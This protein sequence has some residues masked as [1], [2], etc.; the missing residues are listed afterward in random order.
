MT[1]AMMVGRGGTAESG[2]GA[3][4]DLPGGQARA[5]EAAG[6]HLQDV[7]QPFLPALN[8]VG[9]PGTGLEGTILVVHKG[10]PAVSKL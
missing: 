8:G 7:L 2:V 5:R 10:V 6:A 4:M 3:E 1:V 9:Q